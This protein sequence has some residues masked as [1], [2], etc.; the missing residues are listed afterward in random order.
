MTIICA[1]HAPEEQCTWIGSD[2]QGNLGE[3]RSA[4]PTKWIVHGDWAIGC[5]GLWR[6]ANIMLERGDELFDEVDGPFDLTENLRRLLIDEGYSNARDEKAG[7]P[8]DFGDLSFILASPKAIWSI[9]R[10]L[11]FAPLPAREVTA[12][13]SGRELAYGAAYVAEKAGMTAEKV[14]RSAVEA[15]IDRDIRCGG[16]PW[17]RQ[18]KGQ[19]NG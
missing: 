14:I 17:V 8:H 3:V 9:D 10:L 12:A 5:A 18:L 4:S 11:G 13:G 6:T 7:G 19:G 15:V 2:T 1:L 16:A